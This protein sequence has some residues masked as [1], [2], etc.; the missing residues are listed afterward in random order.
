MCVSVCVCLSVSVSV[1]LWVYACVCV[2]LLRCVC[3]CVCACLGVCVC[4][5]VCVCV[6]LCLR[7]C[8]TDSSGQTA[9]LFQNSV[10][11]YLVRSRKL[12][13]TLHRQTQKHG[14]EYGLRSRETL[15]AVA[16]SSGPDSWLGL[17][18]RSHLAHY[19]A[20]WIL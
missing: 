2:C 8:V 1:C 3:V 13:V 5:C 19:S 20:I 16:V 11:G 14:L 17:C 4:V 10:R 18:G 15:R 7:V 6:Y 9:L 12:S